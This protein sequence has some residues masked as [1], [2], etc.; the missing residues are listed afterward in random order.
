MARL[1]E[2]G[3]DAG[4]WGTVLNEFLE[5]SHS[6][7]GTLKPGVINDSNISDVAQT[8][9]TGLAATLA[10]KANT[11]DVVH[12]TTDETI[13]G[14]KI[15]TT[16]PVVP[17]PSSGGS[18][19]NKNYVDIL[20]GYNTLRITT[21]TTAAS[22]RDTLYS[23]DASGG[24]ITVQL[25][26]AG[27]VMAGRQYQVKKVDATANA[28]TIAGTSIDGGATAVINTQ[29]EVVTVISDGTEWLII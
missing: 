25:P 18:V 3:K 27:S 7:T 28:V 6:A 4:V 5:V 1:P 21:N 16:S 29:Y 24:P 20:P 15:F 22:D 13:A 14:I 12:N 10:A 23:T 17:L 9:V 19:A 26:A 8:K 11:N 2:P